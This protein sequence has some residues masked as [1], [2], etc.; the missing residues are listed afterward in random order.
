[1]GIIAPTNA[2]SPAITTFIRYVLTAMGTLMVS[3]GMLDQGTADMI[4]GGVIVA[5]PVAH[6]VYLSYRNSK[7]IKA[8]EPYTPDFIIQK[9]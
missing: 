7:T 4:I 1:M 8:A 6:G 3:R 5:L 9:K 2:I